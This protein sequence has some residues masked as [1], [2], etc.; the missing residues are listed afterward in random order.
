MCDEDQLVQV[1]EVLIGMDATLDMQD[2][3][4]ATPLLL[5]LKSGYTQVLL[6]FQLL[7]ISKCFVCRWLNH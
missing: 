5:S 1:A 7:S 6:G 3:D 2:A 4:G